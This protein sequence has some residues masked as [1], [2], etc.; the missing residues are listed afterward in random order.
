MNTKSMNTLTTNQVEEPAPLSAPP[1]QEA[2]GI[3]RTLLA[4]LAPLF[5]PVAAA[6]RAQLGAA[7][8][9][10]SW[11][12]QIQISGLRPWQ[13]ERGLAR[14]HEHDPD[15]PFSWPVFHR[16]CVDRLRDVNDVH[17]GDDPVYTA[18][19][20]RRLREFRALYPGA[21]FTNYP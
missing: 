8:W 7:A 12:T 18:D 9:I 15:I 16:L 19:R 13:I 5:P 10:K 2:V 17:R 6:A 11:S 3:A 20:E 1:R 21:K 14:L 4:H